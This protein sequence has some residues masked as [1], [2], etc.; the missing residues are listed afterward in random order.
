MKLGIE[1]K[2]ALVTLSGDGVGQGVARALAAEGVELLL[3]APDRT[4]AERTCAGIIGDGGCA[5]IIAGDIL[6]EQGARNVIASV[7]ARGGID[8]LVHNAC[9]P[10]S[11]ASDW[12]SIPETIWERSFSSNVMSA[13]RT[14]RAF[15]PGM[16][17]QGWGRIITIGPTSPFAAAAATPDHQAGTAAL[18]DMMRSLAS[19]LAG[20]GVTVNVISPGSA[21]IL[22]A[23]GLPVRPD[24]DRSVTMPRIANVDG[25]TS[26]KTIEEISA[27]AALLVSR[28]SDLTTGAHLHVGGSRP[29]SIN[30]HTAL[31]ELACH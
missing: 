25:E 27:A 26:D 6:T 17:E 11:P 14:I 18:F 30:A 7:F 1:G 10:Q 16:V 5:E 4:G 15:V 28:L 23:P 21:G 2:R 31:S 8:I 3:H 19:A 29:L 24:R 22:I 9:P 13:V 20:S 12:L